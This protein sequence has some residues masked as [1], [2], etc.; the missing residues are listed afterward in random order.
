MKKPIEVGMK[1][2]FEY[3][4]AFSETASRVC[5]TVTL[6]RG[7]FIQVKEQYNQDTF[8]LTRRQITKVWR[9]KPKRDSVRYEYTLG[10]SHHDEAAKAFF[11]RNAGKRACVRIEVL[12]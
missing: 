11:R 1:V 3:G 6:V 10:N 7:D 12:E 9:K 4:S 5:G 2:E 8:H